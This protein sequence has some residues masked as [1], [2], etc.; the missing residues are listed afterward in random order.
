MTLDVDEGPS[1][2]VV[3]PLPLDRESGVGVLDMNRFGIAIASQPCGQVI[4]RIEQPGIAGG[5]RKVGNNSRF[6][7]V[8]LALRSDGLMRSGWSPIPGQP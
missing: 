8:M 4:E 2:D 1:L 6:K 7:N 5:F 3:L